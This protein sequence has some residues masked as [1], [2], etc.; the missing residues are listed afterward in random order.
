MPAAAVAPIAYTNVVA[1]KKLVV[2]FLIVVGCI[3]RAAVRHHTTIKTCD[4]WVWLIHFDPPLNRSFT[5]RKLECSKQ[6][7]CLEYVSM[8]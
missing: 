5:L 7:F 2:G 8:E 1:V 4:D 6:A 3:G